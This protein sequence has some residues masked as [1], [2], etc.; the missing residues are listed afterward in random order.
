MPIESAHLN[1]HSTMRSMP[2]NEVGHCSISSCSPF[3]CALKERTAVAWCA[4]GFCFQQKMFKKN[5]SS[6]N[7]TISALF[8][9]LFK[10]RQ[11]N[12]ISHHFPKDFNSP[13]EIYY[14]HWG[15]KGKLK[16]L[17][18]RIKK[19][20]HIRCW[21]HIWSWCSLPYS[22]RRLMTLES[23]AGS[24]VSITKASGELKMRT[25]CFLF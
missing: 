14:W 6:H 20:E 19:E 5:P 24:Y 18:K 1:G 13:Q 7:T 8:L 25:C 4:G 15:R 9:S 17:Q 22:N 21:E 11:L 16:C 23:Q 2:A 10:P 12:H 3:L